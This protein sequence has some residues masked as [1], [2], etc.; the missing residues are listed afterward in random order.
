MCTIM[1]GSC[2]DGRMKE[3]RLPKLAQSQFIMMDFSVQF[4]TAAVFFSL[5]IRYTCSAVNITG[6]ACMAV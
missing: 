2:A 6:R 5:K 1:V 4:F 3:R